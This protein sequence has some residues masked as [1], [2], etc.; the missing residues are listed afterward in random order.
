MTAYAVFLSAHDR[1]GLLH[2]L[3]KAFA[4]HNANITYVDIHGGDTTFEFTTDATTYPRVMADRA[5]GAG[6]DKGHPAP[7]FWRFCG[8]RIL[9]RGGG[10]QVGQGARAPIPKP[11]RHNI[12]GE[13]ISVDTIPLVGEH[14]LAAA[15]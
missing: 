5:L 8:R 3:T 4:D 9:T 14:E 10:P 12:R 6:A 2:A 7:S 11:H 1:P 13:R 15:V